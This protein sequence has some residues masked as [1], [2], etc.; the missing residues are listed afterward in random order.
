MSRILCLLGRDY[1]AFPENGRKRIVLSWLDELRQSHEVTCFVPRM[2]T[3]DG[4]AALM[5]GLGSGLLAGDALQG[6]L[7]LSDDN[8]RSLAAEIARVSPRSIYVDGGRMVPLLKQAL[9]AGRLDRE[10]YH[11]VVDLDDQMSR[12]YQLYRDKNIGLDLGLLG[13]QLAGY[14]K[15]IGK[16]VADAI[17]GLE[18]R[19]MRA[20]EDDIMAFADDL[21]FS[22]ESERAAM[23]ARLPGARARTHR[24]VIGYDIAP[25]AAAPAG[26]ML[27]FCF[28]GGDKVPQNRMSIEGLSNLW[29]RG[30]IPHR[31][32]IVGKIFYKYD[33]VDNVEFVGFV[34]DLDEYYTSINGLIVFSYLAGGVKTKVPEAMSRG[35]PVLINSVAADGMA[36]VDGY[37]L[38]FDED[39]LIE[40]MHR[41]PAEIRRILGEFCPVCTS[42]AE[43]YYSKQ[44]L[45][46][47]IAALFAG[48]TSSP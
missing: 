21:V 17:L 29:K 6:R 14:A 27:R 10:K 25:L 9:R 45:K 16:P 48:A 28:V 7:F 20:V 30:N 15:I 2:I 1:A 46:S 32:E 40:F 23:T 5:I 18:A 35:V 11:I 13:S 36:G 38:T 8:I 47:Q 39:G 44:K 34:E 33:K 26:D 19:R 31:L 12:R 43:E 22:S 3:Q 41:D 42:I 4:K 37:G 24:Q